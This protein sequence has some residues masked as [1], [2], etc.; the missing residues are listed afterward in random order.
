MNSFQ[1]N[2]HE[3]LSLHRHQDWSK[4]HLL[5]HV[6]DVAIFSSTDNCVWFKELL[7]KT[8]DGKDE[9]L[10]RYLGFDVKR[11]SEGLCLVRQT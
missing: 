6:D 11:T 3:A 8:F 5:V 7:R 4:I 2:P 9:V 10:K 1:P